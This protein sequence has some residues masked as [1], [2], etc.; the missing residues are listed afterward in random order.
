[1]GAV[2]LQPG[3]TT[4]P[5]L[6]IWLSQQVLPPAAPPCSAPHPPPLSVLMRA[7]EYVP[8]A[9]VQRVQLLAAWAP[10]P[11]LAGLRRH[12]LVP[13]AP[14]RV[15]HRTSSE[16]QPK[17][18]NPARCSWFALA[19]AVRAAPQLSGHSICHHSPA[20]THLTSPKRAHTRIASLVKFMEWLMLHGRQRECGWPGHPSS[21]CAACSAQ[22][23]APR[24]RQC[25]E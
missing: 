12:L 25:T 18:S 6:Q 2:Q 15:R 16:T 1:L 14:T 9:R 10:A 5:L 3:L 23:Q 19:A 21:S 4:W 24:A 8:I 22:R 7:C 20:A 13:H 17:N 11:P